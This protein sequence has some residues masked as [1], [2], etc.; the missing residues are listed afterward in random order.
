HAH[1]AQVLDQHRRSRGGRGAALARAASFPSLDECSSAC[2]SSR[3]QNGGGQG[4]VR[5][6]KRYMWSGGNAPGLR[7]RQRSSTRRCVRRLALLGAIALLAAPGLPAAS[8]SPLPAD[9]PAADQYVES[10]PSSSGPHV[11]AGHHGPTGKL[12]PRAGAR[13]RAQ[14]GRQAAA[15]RQIATA[16]ELGAPV[17]RL[18]GHSKAS[19]SVPSAVTSALNGEG[20]RLGWLLI[21]ILVSTSVVA[22]IA[23]HRHLR[24]KSY[25]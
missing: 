15:L 18:R 21:V 25:S 14:G 2:R 11:P 4:S 24:N 12:S 19:P 3:N 9:V 20:A 7:G 5:K 13:L 10:V 17:K 8:A 22:G 6:G 1:P 23:G 16:P